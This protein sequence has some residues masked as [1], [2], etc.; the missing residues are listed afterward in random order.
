MRRIDQ[1]NR[2]ETDEVNRRELNGTL[3]SYEL[4]SVE[5]LSGKSLPEGCQ[6]ALRACFLQIAMWYADK[7]CG[8]AFLPNTKFEI[9]VIDN[10]LLGAILRVVKGIEV[11]EDT[12]SF[13]VIRATSQKMWIQPHVRITI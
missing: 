4:L 1:K 11:S 6:S 2:H 9:Y 10:D 12:L 8:Q 13:D 5:N 3:A 7:R